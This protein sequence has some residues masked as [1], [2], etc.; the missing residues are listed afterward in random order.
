MKISANDHLCCEWR[1]E[2]RCFCSVA[3]PV[4]MRVVNFKWKVEVEKVSLQFET[5]PVRSNGCLLQLLI[6]HVKLNCYVEVVDLSGNKFIYLDYF[7]NN[8]AV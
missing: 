3:F 4:A 5:G 2:L 8:P 6:S 1:T 7:L